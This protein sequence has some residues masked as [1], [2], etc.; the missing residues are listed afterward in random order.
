LKSAEYTS[1]FHYCGI[2]KHFRELAIIDQRVFED[3]QRRLERNL[4]LSR[5]N[6]K[7]EYLLSS[8]L[9]CSKGHRMYGTGYYKEDLFYYRGDSCKEK[10]I[11]ADIADILVW[12]WIVATLDDNRIEPGLNRTAQRKAGELQPKRARLA[13]VEKMVVSIDVKIK[14][15]V[16]DL[17]DEDDEVLRAAVKAEVKNMT[18]QREGLIKDAE[19][20]RAEIGQSEISTEARERIKETVREVQGRL[21]HAT[22]AQKR[23]LVNKLEFEAVVREDDAGLWLGVSWG[24]TEST[25]SVRIVKKILSLL[26]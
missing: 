2:T 16:R 3:A 26:A 14:R 24:L 5:R 20:L 25:D 13:Q 19:S 8:V 22:F 7:H 6:A 9:R 18:R 10:M 17:S 11:R 21:D 1:Q 12:E 4:E 23:F 15:L